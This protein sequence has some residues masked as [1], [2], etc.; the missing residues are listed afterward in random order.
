M[1]RKGFTLIEILSAMI[2][3]SI[4]M[5]VSLQSVGYIN[6]IHQQNEIRYLALNRIDSEM[7]RL[8]MAYENYTKS[9]FTDTDINGKMV[10]KLGNAH[11]AIE[12]DDYGLKIS[13]GAD[14]RNFVQLK[15]IGSDNNIVENG[16]FV[17]ILSWNADINNTNKTANIELNITYPYIY[18]SDSNSYV[19]QL[20]DFNETITL[21][22]STKVK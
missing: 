7:S 21:K 14:K 18:N 22:T 5:V 15:N 1:M 20:W 4:V 6:N 16:D 17:G 12:S 2:I 3:M 10:Y 11:N 19:Q 13:T 9:S 8:V